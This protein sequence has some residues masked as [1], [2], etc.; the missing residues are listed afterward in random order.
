[1]TTLILE[2]FGPFVAVNSMT[3]YEPPTEVSMTEHKLRVQDMEAILRAVDAPYLEQTA[4]PAKSVGTRDGS[5]ILVRQATRAE[6]SEVLKAIR[7]YIDIRKDFYD[8]VAWRTYAEVLAWKMYRIKDHYLLLGIEDGNLVGIANARMWNRDLAI[9]LHTMSFKRGIDV[10]PV[11]Y[12][13]K[14]EYAFDYLGAKEWWATFESY[15]GLRIMGIEWAPKQ[16][17]FPEMQHE[18]GGSRIFYTTKDDWDNFTKRKYARYLGERPAPKN[19]LDKSEKF[20][21]PE[22]AEV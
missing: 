2:R 22:K 12:F 1:M 17:P 8:I 20:K 11:L 7:L 4:Y 21:I 14:M 9:S 3:Y 19:L 15:I 18:L 16:K 6:A 10:G 13:S 5:K